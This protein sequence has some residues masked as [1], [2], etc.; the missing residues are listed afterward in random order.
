MW[1]EALFV[2]PHAPSPVPKNVPWPVFVPLKKE[3]ALPP[4]DVDF[5][6]EDV[7]LELVSALEEVAS[8]LEEVASALVE[9]ASALVE[10]A[11]LV[12]EVLADSEVVLSP[13]PPSA[14]MRAGAEEVAAGAELLLVV[15][16]L[17]LR[18]CI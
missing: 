17:Q 18:R 7:L 9:V 12:E 14:P 15:R 3:P 13:D 10:V 2:I 8:A 11:S 6:D 5:S 4:V 16:G 1:S